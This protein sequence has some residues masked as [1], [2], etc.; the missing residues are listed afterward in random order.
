MA[1]GT[2]LSG[3]FLVLS[4]G[5]IASGA[6]VS[7]GGTE[8][9]YSGGQALATIVSS[10]GALLVSSGGV[11]SGGLT[12]AGGT[13]TIYGAAGAGQTVDFVGSGGVLALD[14]LPAFAAQISGFTLS[15]QKIDL[16][17]FA[18][19]SATETVSWTSASNN[20]S[21]VLTVT[22]GAQVAHLNLIGAYVTS[23]FVLS[24]DGHGGTYV[25][26][27][28]LTVPVVKG[29]GGAS[30]DQFVQAM[31]TFGSPGGADLTPASSGSSPLFSGTITVGGT[32][33]G[34]G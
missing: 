6:V 14:D 10:G 28:P 2:R 8:Y 23:N 22:D 33:S 24:T 16:A 12:L 21:G 29:G 27:P 26:D 20:T 32:T 31:A 11:V 19:S 7:G 17:G 15:S 3:G 13:A 25:V 34:L 18:Y 1:S 4:S 30:L 5:G 9:V